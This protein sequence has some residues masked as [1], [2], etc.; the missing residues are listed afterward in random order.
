MNSKQKTLRTSTKQVT[1]KNV[2][3]EKSNAA[4]YVTGIM[5]QIIWNKMT[6]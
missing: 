4:Y 3:E 2:K 5:E 6:R 1:K